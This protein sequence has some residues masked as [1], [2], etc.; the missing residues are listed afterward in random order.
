MVGRRV[1]K[2]SDEVIAKVR[3]L[4]G[5]EGDVAVI[6]PKSG[7]YFIDK[8]LTFAMRKARE[9]FPHRLF[10]CMRL[11]PVALATHKGVGKNKKSGR[12]RV[13]KSL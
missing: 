11:G 12:K 10:Y 8:N 3:S 4:K 9:V 13:V 2:P 1:Q 6:E 5:H 7:R